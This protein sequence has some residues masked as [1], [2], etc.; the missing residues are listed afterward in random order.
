MLTVFKVSLASRCVLYRPEHKATGGH[1]KWNFGIQRWDKSSDRAQRVDEK[2]GVKCLKN[3][4]NQVYF[5][6]YGY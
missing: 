6:S 4:K 5:Q 2:N 1:L 3:S